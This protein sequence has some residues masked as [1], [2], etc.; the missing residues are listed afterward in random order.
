MSKESKIS[1]ILGTVKGE[2][3][4]LGTDVRQHDAWSLNLPVGVIDARK[5]KSS[6]FHTCAV[7]SVGNILRIS[8]TC[9]H[10]LMAKLFEIYIDMGEEE[11]LNFMMNGEDAEEFSEV[12]SE[13]QT[14]KKSGALVWG[15]SDA[16]A[17]VTKSREAF[18]DREIAVAIMHTGDQGQ[19]ELTTC[20]VPWNF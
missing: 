13:Y 3:L 7:G 4:Q 16:S 19:D 1:E 9:E 5:G 14:E 8:T 20:C 17:F 6:A 10:P 2:L 15:A 11:A 18:A 12:F